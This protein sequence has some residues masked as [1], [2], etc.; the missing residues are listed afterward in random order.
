MIV[1]ARCLRAFDFY[2]PRKFSA[3]NS[4]FRRTLNRR[5]RHA[6]IN[7]YPTFAT[8]AWHKSQT[9]VR[10]YAGIYSPVQRPLAKVL[11]R[12]EGYHEGI[13]VNKMVRR[14]EGSIPDADG[15][16]QSPTK[17]T[18]TSIFRPLVCKNIQS[19]WMVQL[20][21]DLTDH[22]RCHCALKLHAEEISERDEIYTVHEPG[23]Q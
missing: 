7:H 23:S 17:V 12:S 21:P 19:R 16:T 6:P 22:C 18:T 15:L 11:V 1:G 2:R 9:G 4:S 20:F 13:R 10:G 8:G 5:F 14:R 3:W